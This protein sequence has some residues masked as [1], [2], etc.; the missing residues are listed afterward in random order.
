VSRFGITQINITTQI[1]KKLILLFVFTASI[2]FTQ[3]AQSQG[4]LGGEIRWDCIPTGNN[5]GGKYVFFLKVYQA[6]YNDSSA[7][8]VLPNSQLLISNSPSGNRNMTLLSGYPKDLSPTCNPDTS[9]PHTG[10]GIADSISVFNGAYRVYIYVDT[11]ALSGVPPAYGWT[12]SWNGGKR[13]PSTNL[14]DSLNPSMRLRSI[15]YPYG[16][17]S[18]YPCFDNSPI[19]AE[20]PIITTCNGYPFM[21]YP[22]ISDKE[23]DSLH[24]EW[25][26]LKDSTNSNVSFTTN[27]SYLNPLPNTSDNP[28][29]TP[30]VLHPNFGE[31]TLTTYSEGGFFANQKVSAFKC[32]IKVAEIYQDMYF[33]FY[34]CGTNVSPVMQAPFNNGTSS[35]DTVYAGERIS[36]NLNFT[37]SQQL[38]PGV[39]QSLSMQAFGSQ[40]GNY[41]PA[42]GSNPPIFDTTAGCLN[43]PCASLSA[44]P[45][46]SLPLHDTTS[47]STHFTWQTDCGHL[48][49]SAGCGNATNI[50]NFYFK[51]WDDF[52]PVP[53]YNWGKITYVV[54]PRQY[55]GPPNLDS[56]RI[57]SS[58]GDVQLYWHP[59]VDSF[60]VFQ[61]YIVFFNTNKYGYYSVLDTIGSINDTT[62]LHQ[63]ANALIQKR[64]YFVRTESGCNPWA[65]WSTSSDTLHNFI[66]NLKIQSLNNPFENNYKVIA[67]VKNIGSDDIDTIHFRF[68]QPD[69]SWVTEQWTGNLE[70]GNL[71][72][73]VFNSNFQ[74][75]NN[76]HFRLSIHADISNDIDTSDNVIYATDT[77]G[78]TDLKMEELYNPYL[79]PNLKVQV[80]VKNLGYTSF[81]TIRFSFKQPDNTLV[82]ETWTG[83][84]FSGKSLTFRFQQSYVPS[85]HP[86]YYLC[87]KAEVPNDINITNNRRCRSTPLDIKT[88]EYSQFQL[89]PN[90]PNPAKETTQIRFRLPK[91]ALVQLKVFDISGCILMQDN[92]EAQEGDNN[93]SIDV[94]N[95][96]NG[97]FF[98]Q[99]SYH[100]LNLRAKFVVLR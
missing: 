86:N 66:R 59:V 60:G 50:H 80:S 92:I 28:N 53:A 14:V 37:D 48:A 22:A 46:D 56:L 100:N 29:N 64:F 15:M 33:Q 4:L 79:Y 36:I 51:Y 63:G 67:N 9:L 91:A 38:M 12:F 26:E 5:N 31:I 39:M 52:C 74:L 87:V 70:A 85:Y 89:L 25:E 69:S 65:S 18:A 57:V 49:T 97:V 55:I 13:N 83:G 58:N 8:P 40:F 30:A 78:H 1:M 95:F 61:S 88:T 3:T 94:S 42:S 44:A 90:I 34:D 23:L 73:Y 96:E 77:L 82:S 6:C 43:P 21:Y 99:L 19:F 16:T 93:Y 68:M 27:H 32:G 54:M 71:L 24:I 72:S 2:I 10:C 75:S 20:S 11:F 76:P 35:I 98:Y 81:D 45:S 84:L 7:N 41:I 17:Q 47:I 62:Y